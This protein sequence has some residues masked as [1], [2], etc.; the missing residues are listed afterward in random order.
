MTEEI[1]EVVHIVRSHFKGVGV[2][3]IVLIGQSMATPQFN[4]Q[5]CC[6]W[7]T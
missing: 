6:F 1:A 4:Y 2:D 7:K 3:D 5:L